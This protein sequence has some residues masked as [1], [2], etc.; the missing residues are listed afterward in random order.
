VIGLY[1]LAAHLVGDYLLQTR[2]QADGKFGWTD[3][4][5]RLRA[6]HCAAYCLPFVPIAVWQ[7]WSAWGPFRVAYFL[8]LLWALHFFTD[9]QRFERT[10]G[11]W[12]VWR[13]RGTRRP[14]PPNP[15]PSI[16]LAIDQSLH[17][18]QI[19]ALAALFLS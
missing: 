17:V 1:L 15:W 3:G 18:V 10:P 4:A 11:E 5:M 16:G 6:R 9:A 19:A 7:N 14:L 8:M 12:L 13:R 2:W